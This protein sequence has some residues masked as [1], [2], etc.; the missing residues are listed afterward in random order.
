MKFIEIKNSSQNN[1]KNVS[2]KIPLGKLTVVCGLSGSGKSSLAFETLYAEGQRRYL[3]NLSNYVRQYV[4]RQSKP[5]VEEIKNL[6]PALAL[7]Q[8][9]NVRSSRSIVATTSGLADHLRLL[10][11]K[12]GLPLCPRHK[13]PLQGFSPV[14]AA[15]CLVKEFLNQKVFIAVPLNRE[16]ISSGS[17]FL[18]FLKQNGFSRLL[19]SK[20][21]PVAFSLFLT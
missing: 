13:L 15:D 8:K 9:N 21:K 11:A 16:N 20:K 19:V 14:Q 12:L 4:S 17:A 18:R 2:V 3:E 10:F 6:P 5:E 1:L 7:E